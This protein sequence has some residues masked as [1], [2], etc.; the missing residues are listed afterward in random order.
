MNNSIPD[1]TESSGDDNPLDSVHDTMKRQGK[2]TTGK[3]FFLGRE[4]SQSYDDYVAS[5]T[6]TTTHHAFK[7]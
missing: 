1:K 4:I 7:K 2:T 3:R 5:Q 6:T